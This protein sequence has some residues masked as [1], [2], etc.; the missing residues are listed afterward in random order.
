[1]ACG[2]DDILPSRINN[3]TFRN[4]TLS[5]VVGK[6][7]RLF[8]DHTPGDIKDSDY[9]WSTAD[10]KVA[11]V[12]NGIVYGHRV[13]ETEVTVSVRG[14]NVN[15]KALI[16]ILPVS[17][18]A[19]KL[20][21]SKTTLAPEE[22]VEIT[23]IIEPTDLSDTDPLEIEWNS[24]D[25][26]VCTV[27]GG[28][29]KAVGIGTAK[30][31]AEIKGTAIKGE[32][33]IYV[34]PVPIGSIELSPA[35]AEL[36]VGK[37]LLL[38]VKVLPVNADDKTLV[39][40]SSNPQVATVTG[41]VVKGVNVGITTIRVATVDGEKSA[42]CTVTVKSVTVDHIILSAHSLV[43]VA[44][45]QRQIIATIVPEEAK[46]RNVTWV[47][48]DNSIATVDAHG[49]VTGKKPGTAII[50]AISVANPQIYA[51]CNLAVVNPEDQVFTVLSN[52]GRVAENGY[53]SSDVNTLFENGSSEPVRLISFE[54][55]S[56]G[57][58]LIVSDYQTR[59]IATGMQ[60][61]HQAQV[62]K[63]YRPYVRYIFE[64]KGKRYER[65]LD[66]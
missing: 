57:G 31:T 34:Q 26:Q 4:D 61:R 44:G 32:L 20:Q 10:P 42:F 64:L 9:I 19:L 2:R 8:V 13:G 46:E 27:N 51:S 60:Q 1:M 28:K 43:M 24:S 54:I 63:V 56:Q 45:Q 37:E 47:S 18:A 66:I 36:H 7:E 48:S 5:L 65:R 33:T 14:Q 21:V 6:S 11:T 41:G 35:Q 23:Y 49:Q 62:K 40:S 59:I 53:I 25:N 50:N 52:R 55:L 16:R 22:E 17:L 38:H 30:V 29:L 15:A 12:E 58:E 3:I 39:W